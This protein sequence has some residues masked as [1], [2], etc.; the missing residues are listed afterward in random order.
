MPD[1]SSAATNSLIGMN[2]SDLQQACGG[3]IT[4]AAAT[5]L[6]RDLYHFGATSFEELTSL[7]TAQQAALRRDFSL[8]LPEIAG[9]FDSSDG[10]ARYLLRLHDG[11]TLETVFMPEDGRATICISTQVGCPVECRFCLT[12]KMGLERNLTAGEIVGQ[13]LA[14]SQA[15]QLSPRLDHLNIVMMGMGEP[16]LNLPNVV[17]ACELLTHPQGIGMPYRRVTVSTSGIIPKIVELSQ[18]PDAIRPQLAISLNASYE[19]Q[20][21]EIMPITRKYS[22][23]ELMEVC[24]AYPLRQRENLMI[25]YVMLRGVNDSIEDAHRVVE[26]IR[27][28]R[29]VVNLIALNPGPDIPFEMPEVEAVKAFQSVVM[30]SAL[31]FVRKPRGRDIYAACGQL[32]RTVEI[33]AAG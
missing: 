10:T 11:K 25:E 28:L 1:P 16:L 22:L 27:G 29:C 2:C 19:E 18:L 30:K 8:G 26:L 14:V 32:K 5:R 3:K 6:F 7:S 15:H 13:L 20:R 31:C 9:R 33:G 21:R 4:D 24:R 23:G 12:A 17:R